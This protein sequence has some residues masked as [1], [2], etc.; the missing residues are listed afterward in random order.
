MEREIESVKTLRITIAKVVQYG[1]NFYFY[2]YFLPKWHSWMSFLEYG[3]PTELSNCSIHCF[4]DIKDSH[5]NNATRH[6]NFNDK[7]HRSG[8]TLTGRGKNGEYMCVIV[9]T[10]LWNLLWNKLWLKHCCNNLFL[11]AKLLIW[12]GVYGSETNRY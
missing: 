6:K 9:S 1:Y 2:F 8:E 3:V 11:G 7:F 10:L 5:F 12:L 4:Q